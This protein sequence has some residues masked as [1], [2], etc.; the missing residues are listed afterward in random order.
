MSS[1]GK[2]SADQVDIEDGA[3]DSDAT[4][5]AHE[6]PNPSVAKA[7]GGEVA[8]PSDSSVA[9]PEDSEKDAGQIVECTACN[10]M[11]DKDLAYHLN[12]NRQD[13]K[14]KPIYRCKICS[15]V[16]MVLYREMQNDKVLKAAHSKMTKKERGEW[17]RLHHEE[18]KVATADMITKSMS[19]HIRTETSH[20]SNN[21]CV[22]S[23]EVKLKWMDETD[24]EEHFKGKPGVASELLKNGKT[25][26]CSTTKRKL[27]GVPDYEANAVESSSS[28]QTQSTKTRTEAE[29][30]KPRAAK[31]PRT[32]VV[33]TTISE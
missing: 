21:S 29:V 12:K 24:V 32:T 15:K 25:Y 4:A 8:G 6:D 17:L 14:K 20:T 16:N 27:F 28:R 33:A 10:R 30:P 26:W 1:P 3:M 23:W 22:A 18:F 2:A 7:S 31:K 13:T 5:D 9:A 11:V 19:Q